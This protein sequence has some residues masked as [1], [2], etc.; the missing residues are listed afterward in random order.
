MKKI[1][2]IF[3]LVFTLMLTIVV[4]AFAISDGT[5]AVDY[6]I[7]T[8]T[9]IQKLILP[10]KLIIKDGKQYAELVFNDV[11]VDKLYLGDVEI[12]PVGQTKSGYENDI[13]TYNVFNLPIEGTGVDTEFVLHTR[14]NNLQ[15]DIYKISLAAVDESFD[16]E[17]QAEEV[18]ADNLGA[19]ESRF[20]NWSVGQ[21]FSIWGPF[22]FLAGVAAAI[23]IVGKRLEKN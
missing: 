15:T 7:S 3:A 20:Y 5:Y 6:T 9:G 2:A 13:G 21:S 4:P 14:G 10:A 8:E 23:F 18:K 16:A 12:L 22:V 11:E 19:Q 1:L 17:A